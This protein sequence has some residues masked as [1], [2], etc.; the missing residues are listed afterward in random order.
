MKKITRLFSQNWSQ[1]TSEERNEIVFEHLHKSYGAY[2]IRTNYDRTLLKA[3]FG[4]GAFIVFLTALFLLSRVL[5][6]PGKAVPTYDPVVFKTYEKEKEKVF[7]EVR[8]EIKS[9]PNKNL[10]GLIPEI[11]KDSLPDLNNDPILPSNNT[12]TSN[13]NSDTSSTGLDLGNGGHTDGRKLI[14]EDTATYDGPIL[15]EPPA[16]PGGDPALF[17]YL[18]KNVL[19]PESVKEIGGK[20]LVGVSFIIDK[21]GYVTGVKIIRGCGYTELNNEA[22][23]VIKNLPQ[24][25]PGKQQ[26]RPVKVRMIL[27]IRFELKQ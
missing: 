25:T 14:D 17:S 13:N 27:P 26:G 4:A 19:Y 23:R 12:N 7:T 5:P 3:F 16:F 9:D 11:R 2:E 20:G 18:K 10:K 21:E 1:V 15:E 6:V 22:M 8:Q 24:W